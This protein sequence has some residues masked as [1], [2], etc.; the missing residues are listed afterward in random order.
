MGYGN[1][2]PAPVSCCA[3]AGA[4]AEAASAIAARIARTFE[5]IFRSPGSG[6]SG[7][8]PA[9]APVERDARLDVVMRRHDAGALGD[10]LHGLD[11]GHDVNVAERLP[12]EPGDPQLLVDAVREALVRCPQV[13]A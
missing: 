11:V 6:G 10:V 7:L 2:A 4:T 12:V 9:E 13:D 3:P 8:R 5:F 1:V